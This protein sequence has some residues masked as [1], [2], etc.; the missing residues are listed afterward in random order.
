MTLHAADIKTST[1]AQY[2]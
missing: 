1:R 2:I